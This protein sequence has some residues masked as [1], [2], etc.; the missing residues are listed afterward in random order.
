VD[1]IGDGGNG[2]IE[3][4]ETNR[5]FDIAEAERGTERVGRGRLSIFPGTI[6]V[7]KCNVRHVHDRVLEGRRG[8][9]R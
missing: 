1:S 6:E 7:G 3:D 8:E 4:T 5:E 9:D 2:S